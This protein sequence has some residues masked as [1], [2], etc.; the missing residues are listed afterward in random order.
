MTDKF[1]TLS[2]FQMRD[3]LFHFLRS[4][5]RGNQY[6]I[7]RLHNQGLLQADRDD[8]MSS[9]LI[10]QFLV[11]ARQVFPLADITAGILFKDIP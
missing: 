7:G 8:H 5:E 1:F 11:S 6:R 10:R 3:H 9:D 2:L 4:G